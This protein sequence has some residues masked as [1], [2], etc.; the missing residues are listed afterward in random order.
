MGKKIILLTICLLVSMY[1]SDAAMAGNFYL[2]GNAGLV[3]LQDTDLTESS[4]SR[5]VTFDSG[6]GLGGGGGYDFDFMR[7]EAEIV[8]RRNDV[9]KVSTAEYGN[10]D[11]SGDM[12]SFSL[13]VNGFYDFKN[14]TFLTPYIG[15]GVGVAY[16]DLSS[17][18]AETI[19]ISG[20]DSTVFAYQAE[21][22]FSSEIN[23]TMSVDLGYRYF[24]TTDPSLGGV[25]SEYKSH[26]FLIRFRYA[27]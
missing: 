24:A 5:E 2:N 18:S 26:N 25:D 10:V 23:E 22:G 20:G 7:V 19:R 8:Y 16:V 27:F 6:F 11:G 1:A 12:S 14:T 3:W 17:V 21:I 13:M 9:N 4:V 15:A